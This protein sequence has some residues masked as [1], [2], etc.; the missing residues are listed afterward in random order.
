MN[1][2]YYSEQVLERIA[3]HVITTYDSRL[4]FSDPTA[5]PIE[6][7]IEAQGLVLEYQYL[8]NNGRVLGQTVFDDG[9]TPVYDMENHRYDFLAVKAGTILIDSSLCEESVTTG[10]LRFTC[11]HELA[12]WLL[13][14]Q[15][16]KG[17]GENAALLSA[18]VSDSTLEVQANKLGAMLLLP[19]PQVKRSFYKY[20]MWVSGD[21]LVAEMAALFQV[22]RQA[23]RICLDQHNLL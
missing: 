15:Q 16:F 3:R 11:A 12:H 4:Y 18:N 1:K 9:W 5:I 17:T 21:K 7:I 20:S 8:R 14:K 13:H 2:I 10:R 19:L 6:E 23:M 22:S